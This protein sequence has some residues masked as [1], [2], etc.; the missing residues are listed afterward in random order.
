[1]FA[2]A[3]VKLMLLLAA[4]V[5]A[6]YVLAGLVVGAVMNDLTLGQLDAGLLQSGYVLLR[7]PALIGFELGRLALEPGTAPGRRSPKRQLALIV[8][9]TSSGRILAS[10]D[11][12]MAKRLPALHA[13]ATTGQPQLQ[14]WHDRPGDLF[15]RVLTESVVLPNFGPIEL[16]IGA[17]AQTQIQ[18]LGNL[19]RVLAAVG[20]AG[21][22]V[23]LV[24]GWY[25]SGLILRPI[26]R[27]WHQQQRFVADASHELRTPLAV[28]GSNLDLALSRAATA[29]DSLETLE[30][31]SNAKAEA[32]RMNRLTEDLLMLARSDGHEIVLQR[33]QVDAAKLAREVVE[34]MAPLAEVAGLTLRLD[35]REKD[36]PV[37][38]WADEERMR[39]LLVILVDNAIKYTLAGG[40]TVD[41]SR[42]RKGALLQ[43]QDTGI[44]LDPQEAAHVFDRFYRADSVRERVSGGTGLGLS[45]A[46]WIVDMHGGRLTVHSEKGVGSVFR[47]YIPD[48]HADHAGRL[49][50]TRKM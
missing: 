49:R 18:V 35:E 25:L 6:L 22:V 14:T 33:G 1:M 17:D 32:R 5:T 11:M 37:P 40:I 48:G 24:V 31:V 41:V 42:L 38:M 12:A 20:G 16:Q 21:F 8:V 15:L 27:S 30:W 7:H 43:V 29:G 50:L 23:V 36:Q 10:N 26:A 44:G 46:R 19:W 9:R 4:I 28:I 34:R 2:S 3:R 13:P 47:A 39:Q 45:I